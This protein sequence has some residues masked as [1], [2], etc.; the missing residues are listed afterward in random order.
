MKKNYKTS[1]KVNPMCQKK[2]PS[3]FSLI[4]YFSHESYIQNSSFEKKKKP[5]TV[6]EKRYLRGCVVKIFY[7]ERE[8]EL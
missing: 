4:I 2:R 3:I 1:N 6:K 8:N 7:N 5:S